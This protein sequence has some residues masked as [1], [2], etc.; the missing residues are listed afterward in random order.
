M[1]L[2]RALSAIASCTYTYIYVCIYVCVCLFTLRTNRKKRDRW[3][4][5]SAMYR[6]C[7]EERMQRLSKRTGT[8]FH[9]SRNCVAKSSVFAFIYALSRC[10]TRFIFLPR[11]ARLY[12]LDTFVCNNNVS[13]GVRECPRESRKSASTRTI[14][15]RVT[16]YKYIELL[17]RK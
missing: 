1:K 5:L 10:A 14:Y 6:K 11:G 17:F 12:I 15:D 16:S 3:K 2:A 13:P 7:N 9:S 4:F 8:L